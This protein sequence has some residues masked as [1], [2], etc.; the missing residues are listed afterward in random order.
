MLSE[1]DRIPTWKEYCPAPR[2]KFFQQ[3]NCI[4]NSRV[5]S[6]RS[7]NKSSAALA[8]QVE[9]GSQTRI[10]DQTAQARPRE[11]GNPVRTNK[12]ALKQPFP[13]PVRRSPQDRCIGR[14][15]GSSGVED[16]KQTPMLTPTSPD[17]GGH[18]PFSNHVRAVLSPPR[19]SS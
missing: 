9:A 5:T 11:Q 8:A 17:R 16:F 1:S 19:Y 7:I 15:Y 4:I 14:Y 2:A 3:V 12:Q 10:R 13:S 18:A 6:H